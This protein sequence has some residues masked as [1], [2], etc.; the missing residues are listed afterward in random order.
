MQARDGQA[1]KLK[2]LRAKLEGFFS[3]QVDISLPQ[4]DA[5]SK[6]EK[7]TRTLLIDPFLELI[8]WPLWKGKAR[9]Y[10]EFPVPPND[11]V[12][13]AL[14]NKK[15][16]PIIVIE[17]KPTSASIEDALPPSQL[18]RYVLGLGSTCRVGAWTNGMKWYW[19]CRDYE[20]DVSS[21]PFVK[22]NVGD[23]DWLTPHVLD[24]L[25]LVMDQFD[26]PN[27]TALHDTARRYEYTER[28]RSWWNSPEKSLTAAMLQRLWKELGIKKPT[29][30]PS[31]LGILEMAWNVRHAKPIDSTSPQP[32]NGNTG[33]G[34]G[35]DGHRPRRIRWDT[36]ELKM[37][38]DHKLV[39][40][41]LKRAWRVWDQNARRWGDWN[42]ENSAAKVQA[43]VVEWLISW[44]GGLKDLPER[45][46]GFRERPTEKYP[47]DWAPILDGSIY[48]KTGVNSK[49]KVTWLKKLASK[50]FN[51]EYGRSPGLGEDFEVWLPPWKSP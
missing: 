30:T 10:A 8:G 50:V 44:N 32:G 38:D 27:P 49:S 4:I 29:P 51:E 13:Y 43:A 37:E 7:E 14:L 28:L 11:K 25:D 5:A 3:S 2:Q 16:E 48:V 33:A 24:W 17:V 46:N 23:K 36:P 40:S 31:E 22:F 21:V 6:P 26:D 15:G 47:N 12:D 9:V 20:N 42:V 19:F 34:N 41:K 1:A 45:I 18:K 35:N 39:C